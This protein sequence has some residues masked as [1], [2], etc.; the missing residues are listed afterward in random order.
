LIYGFYIVENFKVRF[1]LAANEPAEP[2]FFG[3]IFRDIQP[4]TTVTTYALAQNCLEIGP[5]TQ[6]NLIGETTGSSVYRSRWYTITPDQVLG[7]SVSYYGN[8]NYSAA[9]TANPTAILWCAF[10]MYSIA[11]GTNL[12]NGAFLQIKLK[13]KTRFY[14]TAT[15][16]ALRMHSERI[17]RSAEPMEDVT[18]SFIKYE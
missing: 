1:N 2:V 11:A 15:I 7:A 17:I 18:P 14:S 9:V 3:L 12:T 13:F 8:A 6:S 10:I 4:S 5:C 16:P